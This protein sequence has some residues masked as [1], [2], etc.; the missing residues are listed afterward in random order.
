MRRG[1]SAESIHRLT[2]VLIFRCLYNSN[3]FAS[4]RESSQIDTSAF[5][6][7]SNFDR[8]YHGWGVFAGVLIMEK[9]LYNLCILYIYMIYMYIICIYI[10]Y[11]YI[12]SF[13]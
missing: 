8:P 10:Y 4:I 9:S 11:V 13:I 7:R 1:A 6:N 12:L 5:L 2:K 3:D